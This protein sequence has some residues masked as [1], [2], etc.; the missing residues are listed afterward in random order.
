M[1]VASE[2][3]PLN[4]C[5]GVLEIGRFQDE[6][7]YTWLE[8]MNKQGIKDEASNISSLAVSTFINDK[9]CREA[10][11]KLTRWFPVL[12][13]SPPKLSKKHGNEIVLVIFDVKNRKPVGYKAPAWPFKEIK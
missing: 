13:Q 10:Y 9:V 12:Y 6:A 2:Q 4:Q 3:M 1:K 5:C 7:R 11:N 8:A